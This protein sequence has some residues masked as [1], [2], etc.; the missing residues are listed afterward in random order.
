[1]SFVDQKIPA[2]LINLDES[3]DRLNIVSSG[4]ERA[5]I[6]FERVPAVDGRLLDLRTVED[7][8][9]EKA[10]RIYG[11][12]LTGGEYGCYKS[13]LACARRMLEDGHEVALVF[14]DDISI[15]QNLLAV[16]QEA[17]TVLDGMV[18]D[19]RLVN[20]GAPPR[21]V[22]EVAKLSSGHSLLA[23]HYFPQTAHALLWSRQGAKQFVQQYSRVEMTVDNLFRHVLVREG[24]GYAITPALARQEG[25]SSTIDMGTRNQRYADRRWNYGLLKQKRFWTNRIIAAYRKA[26]F[27]GRLN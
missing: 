15:D 18:S 3:L 8:D 16:V 5:G 7:C 9:Y 20:L 4:L 24:G 2:Y 12:A 27:R 14:E 23:A 22:S 25:F 19:W 26:T 11:R 13:H 6:S 17:K 10:L 21:I 1:M